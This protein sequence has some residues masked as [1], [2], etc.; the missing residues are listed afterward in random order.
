MAETEVKKRL[1]NESSK[2]CEKDETINKCSESVG[3][4][5][6]AGILKLNGWKTT[7][8]IVFVS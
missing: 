2:K 4:E 3:R 6:L 7:L 5:Y 1:L 8:I